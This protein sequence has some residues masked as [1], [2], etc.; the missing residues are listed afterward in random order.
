MN[1]HPDE[2]RVSRCA[3][4]LGRRTRRNRDVGRAVSPAEKLVDQLIA[5]NRSR[6][7]EDAEKWRRGG[8]STGQQRNRTFTLDDNTCHLFRA[9]VNISP[10]SILLLPPA[11]QAR[12]GLFGVGS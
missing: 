12:H 11:H 4:G 10:P 3:S 7:G 2:Q 1:C 5:Q 9:P 6:G 8:T